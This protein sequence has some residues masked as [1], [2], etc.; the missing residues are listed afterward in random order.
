MNNYEDMYL[1]F[2]INEKDKVKF[3][4]MS[5]SEHSKNTKVGML[6]VETTTNNDGNHSIVKKEILDAKLV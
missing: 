1:K 6:S 2:N 5:D 4:V 3:R